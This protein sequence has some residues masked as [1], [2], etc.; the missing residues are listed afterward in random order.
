M[1]QFDSTPMEQQFQG[2]S[3][4]I[5]QGIQIKKKMILNNPK[6]N[7]LRIKGKEEGNVRKRDTL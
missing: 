1:R 2:Q 5:I 7:R 3:Y 4:L 6:K